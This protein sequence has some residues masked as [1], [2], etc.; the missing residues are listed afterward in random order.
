M[1]LSTFASILA[2]CLA[3]ASY[4]LADKVVPLS[5]SRAGLKHDDRRLGR[6]GGTYSQELN[7]NLTGGG[8]YTEVALGTPPQPVTLILDTGSSDVWVLD[9]RADLCRSPALQARYGD[10][11]ATYDPERSSTYFLVDKD[12]FR[13]RYLDSSGAAGDY[14]KDTLSI[15]DTSLEALQVGLAESSTISSGLLGIGFSTNVAA[16]KPYRNIIDLFVDQ[17]LIDTQAYSLYLDDLHAETG[18]ILFGGIDSQKFIGQLK[19]VDILR[20]AKTQDYSSFTVPL[21]SFALSDST[22][23]GQGY[24]I[25]S[26]IPVL[27][28]SGTTLT[29]L[30]P[31]LANQIY[32]ALE[33]YDDSRNTGLVYAN[34]DLLSDKGDATFDFRFGGTDGPLIRVP[35]DEMV[36]DNV[37][38]YVAL[39]LQ[40]PSLPFEN[41]CSFGIQA[42]SDFYL[43]GDT[44]LR[45]A[46]VVYDLAHKKIALAQA[47]LNAT[48]SHILEITK[49]YGIPLVSGV[50]SQSTPS[51]SLI[52]PSASADRSRPT[53]S[54]PPSKSASFDSTGD[55]SRPDHPDRPTESNAANAGTQH[56]PAI[57]GAGAVTMMAAFWSIAGDAAITL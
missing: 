48:E 46:Y 39:G 29:Y 40:I 35:M 41:V 37:K 23:A 24:N 20:D 30:P 53:G 1:R 33:V 17:D 50:A 56:I 27:L 38:G 2:A 57:W 54:E 26:T 25:S 12:G 21:T 52:V 55:A 4:T 9:D 47:N 22:S 28:D 3:P 14:I 45:S 5:F 18:T 36:L 19:A 51:P 32:D 49:T 11:L 43:L 42:L 34:C 31:S 15:A 10:C 16:Y 13:I 44:F 7:N 8:Y 6:R